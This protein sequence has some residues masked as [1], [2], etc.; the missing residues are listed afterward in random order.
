MSDILVKITNP[1]YKTITQDKGVL[2]IGTPYTVAPN[3]EILVNS[4]NIQEKIRKLAE[5]RDDMD[6]SS[7]GRLRSTFGGGDGDGAEDRLIDRFEIN[8]RNILFPVERPPQ[9]STTDLT[10]SYYTYQRNFS[11]IDD[12][13]DYIVNQL[14]NWVN[15]LNKVKNYTTGLSRTVILPTPTPSF[16]APIPT[17]TPLPSWRNCVS[18]E[19]T[20]TSIPN[21]WIKTTFTGPEG[22]YCH[23]PVFIS[24]TSSSANFQFNALAPS[25]DTK[26][27]YTFTATSPRRY[28]VSLLTDPVFTITPPTFTLTS[29]SSR[30]VTASVAPVS[31]NSFLFGITNFRLQMNITKL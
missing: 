28:M 24:I 4:A 6:T 26:V 7:I 2:G 25:T 8:L 30:I 10:K 17:P 31:S 13:R 12:S 3:D 23:E 14:T 19:L 5:L 9:V 22:G 27:F 20:Q 15:F 18:G 29:G 16:V 11:R 21:N 1:E